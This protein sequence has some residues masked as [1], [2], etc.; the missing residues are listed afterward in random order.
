MRWRGASA[1]PAPGYRGFVIEFA[2][3]VTLEEDLRAAI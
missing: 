2:P 1:R 3:E